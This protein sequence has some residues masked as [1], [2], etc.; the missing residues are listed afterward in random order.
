MS[1]GLLVSGRLSPLLGCHRIRMKGIS[2][3]DVIQVSSDA[4]G[5]HVALLRGLN[6]GGKNKLPMLDLRAMFTLAGCEAVETYIQSG[7]VVF[8]AGAALATRIPGLIANAIEER[9]DFR[10]P[11]V[12]RT[13]DELR[14]VVASNP[15][16]D[17]LDDTKTLHVAFLADTP[18]DD[19]V[20]QLDPDRSP[21][22]AFRVRGREIFLQC[23]SGLARTRLTNSYF[24]SK[25]ATISTV[26]N[27]RTV[28]TLL[29]M[30]E[31]K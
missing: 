5:A 16:L 19:R 31:G 1:V 20:A 25:L 7:N 12:L 30:A 4:L 8:R 26:R 22:D 13:V 11:V 28:L 29:R 21:P 2:P 17:V 9:F 24:D 15:F 14:E 18:E 23:P 27:W 3:G 10:V 6:V